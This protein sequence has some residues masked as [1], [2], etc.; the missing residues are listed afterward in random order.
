MQMV[1]RSSINIVM[2]NK[3]PKKLIQEVLEKGYLMSL[4]TT[5]DKK[6]CHRGGSVLISS[7][8]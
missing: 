4:A 8:V 5:D 1:A 3:E 2:G 6:Y 7:Y